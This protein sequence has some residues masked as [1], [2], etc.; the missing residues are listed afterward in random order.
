MIKVS[1]FYPSG[2]GIIKRLTT[3]LNH[4]YKGNAVERLLKP[5]LWKEVGLSV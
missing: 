1:V 4:F 5:R 3:N 2:E